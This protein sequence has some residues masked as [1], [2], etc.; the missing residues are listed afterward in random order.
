MRQATKLLALIALGAIA[1]ASVPAQA[2]GGR[3]SI[4]GVV[5]DASGSPLI[6]AAVVVL[7]DTEAAKVDKVVKRAST[8]GEGKFS[9]SGIAP[10]RYRVKAGAEGFNSVELAADVKS[11]KVTV[12]DS[13]LLRRITTLND[14]TNLN[15][16]SKFAARRVRGTI[17]HYD[18]AKK[19]PAGA[20]DESTVALTA[21]STQLHGAVNVFGQTTASSNTDGGSFAGANFA[22]S[23]QIGQDA[24]LVVSGQLGRGDG[25]P[26]SLTAVTTA[27]TGDRHR[28]SVAMGYGRF[29][30][31]RHSASPRLG[32]FSV[33]ATDTWQV[34]GPVLI[35]YGLEF[36]RF[37][38]RGPGTSI[39][40]RFGVALDAGA[41]TR[42]F[43]A[44]VPGSSSDTQS[45]V[46]LESG[47]IE[48]SEP[49]PVAIAGGQPVME[50]SYRLEFG[51]E[52]ILSDKSSL[53]MMAFF[54]TVSGHGVG[55]LALPN[56]TSKTDP[57]LRTEAQS[58][59]TRGLRVVYHRH[60]NKVID[61]SIGYAFGEGQQLDRRGITTPANLFSN[62]LFHVL[63]AKLDANFVSTGTRVSTVLRLSPGQ[64]MFA[65]DPFQGQIST[66]DPN[67]NVSLTQELP[68]LSFIPGQ[69]AAVVD[70]RNLLDQQASITDERQEL[71]ASRFH[72]LVRIGLSL[73]F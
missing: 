20:T 60:L 24:N 54:D 40:P 34:S 3:G 17:F 9:A 18:E 28:V 8:D 41:R 51:G 32:Q 67:L 55:L 7:A 35:V 14:T 30:F 38:E 5:M 70:L 47:E 39:L 1:Y 6:G 36:A 25:A 22:V 2:A 43:A 11:N 61:G 10:G 12:F 15:A 64:A 59:R 71:V 23:E 31:S 56:D 50:R 62:A 53:E 63:S 46:N 58:G 72:R 4:R 37:A 73:R 29:T 69:W 21:R 19:D 45:K 49:K 48:F 66:Y 13:I 65:I 52:Q 42:V 16:E 68:S 57:V 44:L 33:S 27:H 26:Q